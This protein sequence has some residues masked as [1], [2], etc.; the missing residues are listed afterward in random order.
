M[1]LE[2]LNRAFHTAYFTRDGI[3]LDMDAEDVIHYLLGP[4]ADRYSFQFW[5]G[6]GEI[7][8][9]KAWDG[10]GKE[11]TDFQKENKDANPPKRS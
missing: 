9:V 11:V 1:T 4:V 8:L 10:E 3:A 6:E 5:L 2:E 7:R